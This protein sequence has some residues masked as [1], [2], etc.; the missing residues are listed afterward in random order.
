MSQNYISISYP[1]IQQNLE[2]K[3]NFY[4]FKISNLN[5]AP[6]KTFDN[7]SLK[8]DFYSSFLRGPAIIRHL[9]NQ[10]T[11]VELKSIQINNRQ[12][13]NEVKKV[14]FGL[15]N[16]NK[17]LRD[18]YSYKFYKYNSDPIANQILLKPLSKRKIQKLLK[19]IFFSL[20]KKENE[21]NRDKKVQQNI[22]K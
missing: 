14:M 9:L 16:S 6:L 20:E 21:K 22:S 10:F 15:L 18:F 19:S 1:P 8:K 11:T 3:I 4:T 17:E 13:L 5:K 2:E 7:V 12:K